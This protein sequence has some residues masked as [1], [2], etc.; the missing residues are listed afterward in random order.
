M[1]TL[2]NTIQQ[3][4]STAIIVPGPPTLTISYTKLHNDVQV[5]QQKLA[6][7]GVSPQAAVSI[8]LPNSYPFIV[9]FLAASWQRAIAGSS[10]C[11]AGS[12][13][14]VRTATTYDALPPGRARPSVRDHR[15]ASSLSSV[16]RPASQHRPASPSEATRARASGCSRTAG[17]CLMRVAGGWG[18]GSSQNCVYTECFTCRIVHR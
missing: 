17:L 12:P 8:A 18:S 15:S 5:F 3:G 14:A 2:E 9:A 6:S 13:V 1:S 4:A 10:T 16:G 11:S 7:L